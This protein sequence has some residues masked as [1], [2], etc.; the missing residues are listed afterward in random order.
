M[1]SVVHSE[2]IV[3]QSGGSHKE[4]MI[5]TIL[6]ADDDQVYRT[7]LR[8]ILLRNPDVVAVAEAGD[9]EEAVAIA[10]RMRPDVILTDFDMPGPDGL[11]VAR[12]PA[13]P[14][15]PLPSRPRR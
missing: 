15:S 10:R 4:H 7:F 11:E 3:G 13:G 12:H 2:G 14:R 5:V 9:A 8:R 1:P 6:I